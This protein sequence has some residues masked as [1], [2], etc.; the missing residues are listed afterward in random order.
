MQ[1]LMCEND[2]VSSIDSLL[3]VGVSTTRNTI[4]NMIGKFGSG[5]KHAICV[6]LRHHINSILFS[7]KLKVEFYTERKEVRDVDG[8]VH[9]FRNVMAR[10]SGDI[11]DGKKINRTKECGFA[12]E[13]GEM[14]W[15]K[16]YM[17]L[18]EIISNSIDA[19][20]KLYGDK[21]CGQ[22]L[23]V[24]IVSENQ[25]RAKAGTTRVF[26]PLTPDVQAFYNQ[27][28]E[29][30]L[31]FNPNLKFNVYSDEIIDKPEPSTL[32]IY[33]KGVLIGRFPDKKSLFDYNLNDVKLDESRNIDSYTAE[34]A[35]GD[36]L[37]KG[38][39]QILSK[40]IKTRMEGTK[41]TWESK[42]SEY[43][44]FGV[45]YNSTAWK[46]AVTE[47]VG[48]GVV[49][50][51]ADLIVNAVKKKGHKP[52]IFD[53][54]LLDAVKEIGV[55]T[56]DDVLSKNE[57]DG[58]VVAEPTSELVDI[59]KNMWIRLVHAGFTNKTPPFVKCFTSNMNGE[60]KTLGYYEDGTVFIDAEI[61]GDNLMCKQTV[62]EELAHY[63][64]GSTDNSR[65]FQDFAFR[66]ATYFMEKC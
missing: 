29:F 25:V 63:I 11:G 6:L 40:F 44:L 15:T 47:V 62:L 53:S 7:D 64:T 12:A 65:D 1:Y 43:R 51:K 56:H 42:F 13:F 61:V 33:R 22:G 18:R 10:L 59:V 35:C 45:R 39:P 3:T 41:E 50:D 14:D 2:G 26:I 21:F 34:V 30:F 20:Q 19:A 8:S 48:D 46:E 31:V 58:K 5:M 16:V 57:K 4:G 23:A 66:V 28:Q 36:L 60:G 52:V 38:K 55:K 9:S 32:K 27:L 17:G 49:C 24:R 54:A 37:C